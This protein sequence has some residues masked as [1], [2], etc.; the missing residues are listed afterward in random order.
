MVLEG[1]EGLVIDS[2]YYRDTWYQ[3]TAKE[4]GGYSLEKIDPLNTCGEMNN[5][6][7]SADENG[8]TPGKVN[9]VFANNIDILPPKINEI[10][11]LSENFNFINFWWK[12]IYIICKN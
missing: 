3:N 1:P 8:G 10:K 11:I 4:N 5:W 9:S 7:A 6:K 12:D 2:V